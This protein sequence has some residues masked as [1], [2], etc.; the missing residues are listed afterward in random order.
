MQD[1]SA[2]RDVHGDVTAKIIAAI[3]TNPL[4]P[5]M[6][7]HRASA[8]LVLPVN[9]ATGHAYQGINIVTLWCAAQQAGYHANTWGTYKQWQEKDCQVRKGEKASLVVFYRQY[10]TEPNPDDE[11]D[12][13]RRRVAKASWAFNAQQ[14]DGYCPPPPPVDHGPIDRLARVDAFTAAT[15]AD[16]RHGGPRAFYRPSA[17]YIQM[18]DEG[19]FTGTAT[20]GRTES[21]YA[22][23][24][25]EL[26]HWVG[27]ENRLNRQFGKRFGDDAYAIEEM[28]AEL[29]AAFLSAELGITVEPRADHAHY[30][31]HWLSILK[32][33]NRA[34]FAAAAKASE[35]VRYLAKFS[36]GQ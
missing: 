16:I 23:L 30:I 2:K 22:V 15:K 36:E 35:A 34:I 18:P 29:G 24:L 5:Q 13:G 20:S 11:G 25:H 17:D 3:E 8:P 19:L 7:W 28:V 9:I 1:K 26:T 33:D 14:V 10:D 27:A 6:P 31:G 4:E 12:D 32:A 21:Y